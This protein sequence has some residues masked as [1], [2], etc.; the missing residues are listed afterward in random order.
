MKCYYH[1]DRDAVGTCSQCGKACCHECIE[2]IGGALLCKDCMASAIEIA[3]E[4]KALAVKRAKRSITWSWIITG[5]F[6]FFL[7]PMA[8]VVMEEEMAG[9]GVPFSLLV[10]YI[11]WSTYWGLKVVWPWWWNL[12]DRIGCFLIANPITLFLIMVSFFYIPLMIAQVYGVCGG[13]IY[14]YLKYRRIAKSEV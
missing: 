13:G 14:Q 7:A 11:I 12:V 4:E 9:W 6:S 3:V 5:I 2:D 8:Y 1:P 10:I